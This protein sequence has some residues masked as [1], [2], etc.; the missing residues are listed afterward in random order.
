REASD[1]NTCIGVLRL[2]L[3]E[4]DEL[5]LVKTSHRRFERWRR[6]VEGV[7]DGRPTNQAGSVRHQFTQRDGRGTAARRS[8]RFEIST[9]GGVKIERSAFEKLHNAEVRKQL[10]HRA[11][12]VDGSRRCR[13]TVP[14]ARDSEAACPDNALSLDQRDR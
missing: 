14:R 3:W 11:D 5:R 9:Y 12:S 2:G 1:R 13:R 8:K 10:T 6:F 4:V 7:T